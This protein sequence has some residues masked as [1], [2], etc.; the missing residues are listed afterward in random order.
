MNLSTDEN[1][2]SYVKDKKTNRAKD[3]KGYSLFMPI[4]ERNCQKAHIPEYL[5]SCDIS[6]DVN[7]N[8][9]II[10]KASE[11]MVNYINEI[12]LKPHRQICAQLSLSKIYDA[13]K[14]NYNQNKFTIIFETLPS[15]AT[16]D[17]TVLLK[18]FELSSPKYSM[19]RLNNSNF[20]LVG[21]I[22]R[23]NEYGQ[24]SRCIRDYFLKNFCYCMNFRRK[25]RF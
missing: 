21:K 5:C 1:K 23:I 15:N 12:L 20:D 7:I 8:S 14:Y 18:N 9:S 2:S 11:F 19:D 16:F 10:Q 22:V 17:G 24:T 4:P 6:F 3:I 13:Q 25:L